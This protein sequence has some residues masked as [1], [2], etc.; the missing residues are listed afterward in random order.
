MTTENYS[1]SFL[2]NPIGGHSGTVEQWCCGA[3]RAAV[4]HWNTVVVEHPSSGAVVQSCTIAGV[5]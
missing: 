4:V 5:Q 3:G 2:R 1:V